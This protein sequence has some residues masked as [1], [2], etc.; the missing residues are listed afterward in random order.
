MFCE[1]LFD[2]VEADDSLPPALLL[3]PFEEINLNRLDARFKACGSSLIE[4]IKGNDGGK[5]GSP[6]SF[7]CPLWPPKR[8]GLTIRSMV[9]LGS[10]VSALGPCRAPFVDV[11]RQE[12]EIDVRIRIHSKSWDPSEENNKIEINILP[13]KSD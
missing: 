13:L 6:G 7:E 12:N 4:S 3:P 8:V 11:C 10:D 5:I 9:V 2:P 1:L